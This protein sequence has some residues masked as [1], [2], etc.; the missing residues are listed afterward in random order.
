MPL[1]Q[2]VFSVL[3]V[4][5]TNKFGEEI[6]ALLPESSY[7]P[8]HYV[9]SVNA[10]QR[11]T[12]EHSYDVIILN[13]PLPDDFGIKFA[14]DVSTSG[15]SVVLL[16]VR[17]EMY[18]AVYEKASP[19]GV[20]TIRKPAPA[21]AISQALDWL[22]TTRARMSNMEHRTVSLQEKMEEIKIINRAKWALIASL[23]MTEA[24]AHR[25]IEK[26]AMDRCTTRREIAEIILKTYK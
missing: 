17:N 25:Y 23:G 18:S 13:T 8:V 14:I 5:G 6:S 4:S 22:R 20:F 15:A 11:C 16:F 12:L 7:S 21:T 2:Q 1:Q 3:V 24:D 10:A 19:C 26:Q 9:S